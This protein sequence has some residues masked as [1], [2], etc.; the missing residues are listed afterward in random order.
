M[1]K[2]L[3]LLAV[4]TLL[5]GAAGATVVNESSY[6]GSDFANSS[7][8]PTPLGV[9]FGCSPFPGCVPPSGF[10]DQ[11]NGGL[12][13][14][15]SPFPLLDS[16][17]AFSFATGAI[18]SIVLNL[19]V[20]NDTTTGDVELYDSLGTPISSYVFTGNVTNLDLL[21]AW[22]LGTSGDFVTDL[23]GGGYIIEVEVTNWN[24]TGNATLSYTFDITA[25]PEPGTYLLVGL[26]L[27]AFALVRRRRR[28]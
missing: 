8:A 26:G 4:F 5:A 14:L 3:A 7:A 17:D 10:T 28:V 1:H 19:N 6:P 25:A 15:T 20:T 9:I 18:D 13:S 12:I 11:V 16:V 24:T 21:D 2:L 27:A 23:A 22:G